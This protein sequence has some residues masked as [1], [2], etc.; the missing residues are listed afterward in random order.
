MRRPGVGKERKPWRIK[1]FLDSKRMLMADIAEQLGISR[2]AVYLTVQGKKNNRK[3]LK[4]LVDH[5]CPVSY[6]DL[7][8]DLKAQDAA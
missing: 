8:E 6:L 4:A 7:P 1:E 5:G 3:V 2:T